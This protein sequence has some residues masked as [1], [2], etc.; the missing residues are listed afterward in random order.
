LDKF[1]NG[2]HPRTIPT[3]FGSYWPSGFSEED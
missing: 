2:D 3:K 1:K